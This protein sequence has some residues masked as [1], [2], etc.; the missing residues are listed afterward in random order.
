MK[1]LILSPYTNA[2][3]RSHLQMSDYGVLTQFLIGKCGFSRSVILKDIAPWVGDMISELEKIEGIEIYSVSPQ[4]K[5]AKKVQ[6]FKYNKTTY[7][8]YSSDFSQAA[9]LVKNYK[10]WKKIIFFSFLKPTSSIFKTRSMRLRLSSTTV[11]FSLHIPLKG[12]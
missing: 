10:L 8:F 7:Y 12:P 11:C 9:R 1:I 4:I 2:E 6:H 3:L 5:M